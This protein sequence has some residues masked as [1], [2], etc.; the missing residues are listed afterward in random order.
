MRRLRQWIARTRYVPRDQSTRTH[1]RPKLGHSRDAWL[2]AVSVTCQRQPEGFSQKA[3]QVVDKDKCRNNGRI[4]Q[5]AKARLGMQQSRLARGQSR[6]S[7]DEAANYH[8]H[9]A[10]DDRDI[11]NIRKQSVEIP[12]QASVIKQFEI[13]EGVDQI[14]KIDQQEGEKSPADESMQNA[15]SQAETKNGLEQSHFEDKFANPFSMPVTSLFC[16]AHC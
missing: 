7:K 12:K 11:R 2:P 14:R 15:R 3:H 5:D 13:R 10:D 6:R 1:P 9:N 16:P 4:A 8:R